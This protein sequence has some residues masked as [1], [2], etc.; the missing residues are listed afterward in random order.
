[1]LILPH[2]STLTQRWRT[3]TAKGRMKEMSDRVSLCGERPAFGSARFCFATGRAVWKMMGRD[4]G[5]PPGW[6]VVLECWIEDDSFRGD[7]G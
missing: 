5:L 3:K 7:E 2:V 6:F 1:V 4:D